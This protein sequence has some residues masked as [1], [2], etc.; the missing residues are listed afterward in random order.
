MT[1]NLPARSK[2]ANPEA[3][4]RTIYGE[5][6]HGHRDILYVPGY[7]RWVM[8]AIQHIPESIGKKLN[9]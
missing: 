4:A 5:L 6:E 2:F 8:M 3:V 9:F 1:A 7:W